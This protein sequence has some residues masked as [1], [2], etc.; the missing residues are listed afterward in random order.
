[1]SFEF[2]KTIFDW[3]AVV[4]VGLTFIAGLGALVTGNVVS[5]RQARKFQIDLDAAK[6][7]ADE[8]DSKR[9]ALQSRILDI[10]GARQ[11]TPEQSAAISKKLAGLKG[12]KIDVYVF[13]F[14][15]PYNR[16]DFG[17][18]SDLAVALVRTLRS[19]GLDAEVWLLESCQDTGA[20][21]LVVGILGNDPH[22]RRI[23]ERVADA[24]PDE[25]GVWPVVEPNLFP[26]TCAKISSLD[27]S[28]QNGRTHDAKISIAIGKKIQPILTREMLDPPDTQ[29]K[30][31]PRNPN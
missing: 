4:L 14:G 20:S 3:S 26:E 7:R 24:L 6:G 23:A 16:T 8:A 15:N 28:M 18:D 10:F 25:I 31:E 2:W 12:T 30:A 13:K 5:D 27:P 22:D 29:N 9:V 11:L 17:H 1:M 19:A 21:N